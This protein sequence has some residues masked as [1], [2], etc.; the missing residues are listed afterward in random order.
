VRCSCRIIGHGVETNGGSYCSTHC[1]RQNGMYTMEE[2]EM[3][4]TSPA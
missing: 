1:A 4:E 2:N 3:P